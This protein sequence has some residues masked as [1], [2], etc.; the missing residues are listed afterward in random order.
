M[1]RKG[2]VPA[3][4]RCASLTLCVSLVRA[5]SLEVA[6]RGFFHMRRSSLC[7]TFLAALLS[8]ALAPAA[9][10]AAIISS[11]GPNPN[12]TEMQEFEWYVGYLARASQICGA[13]DESAVLTRSEE[14]TS[15]LQSL[16]RIS[17]PVLCLEK[18]NYIT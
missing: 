4:L 10:Q 17:Y 11:P 14:H 1:D 9:P 16:M 6:V 3:L 15:A 8:L 12:W 5:I 18:K 13:Y 2:S 7:S